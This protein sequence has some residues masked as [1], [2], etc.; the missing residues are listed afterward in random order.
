MRFAPSAREAWRKAIDPGEGA[1]AAAV[2]RATAE[3]AA[4]AA[5]APGRIPV[6]NPTAAAA[7]AVDT[8]VERLVEMSRARMGH[9]PA[10]Q[11]A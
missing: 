6:D 5:L 9:T 2:A 7:T 1:D 10:K 4:L 11:E 8:D 3:Q